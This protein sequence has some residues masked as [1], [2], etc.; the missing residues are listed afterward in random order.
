MFSGK[1][2]HPLNHLLQLVTLILQS[3]GEL[4]IFL[5]LSSPVFKKKIM[6]SVYVFDHLG[7]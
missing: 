4:R 7:S 3:L 1:L 6:L 5:H 2:P